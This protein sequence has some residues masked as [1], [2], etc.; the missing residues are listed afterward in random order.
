MSKNLT[1]SN[2][3]INFESLIRVIIEIPD[4]NNKIIK[5]RIEY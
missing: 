1:N 2:I 3:R 5:S 4:A